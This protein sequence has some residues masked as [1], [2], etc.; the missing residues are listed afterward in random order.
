MSLYTNCNL[1][2][3]FCGVDREAGKVGYCGE[4]ADLRLGYAGLHNGEEPPVRGAGGSGTIFIYGCNLGCVFCQNYQLSQGKKIHDKKYA[5]YELGRSVDASQFAEIC[6]AL[7]EEGAEN[8]NIVTGSHTAPALAS[9]LAAARSQGLVIPALWNSSGYDGEETLEV[10]RDCIDVY[11]PDLKTLDPEVSRTFYNAANYP[12]YAQKAI[13]AMME[14]RSLR[15]GTSSGKR[16]TEDVIL[17]GV[18][19]RHLILPGALENTRAVLRWFADH[20]TGRALF[21]LMTQYTPVHI[22]SVRTEIPERF[23]S[24]QEYD[25]VM[26]MLDEFGIEDGFCQ[27]LITDANWLPDFERSNPFSSKLSLPVWHCRGV[28]VCS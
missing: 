28:A 26:S 13:L 24:T 27:E 20:C 25:A 14:F 15:F 18:I 5:D 1:C 8:I 19:V 22:P 3:R 23:L 16:A 2:P 10:L 6:L 21:S 7:Q 9:G 12:E 17:S 11:L 4:T